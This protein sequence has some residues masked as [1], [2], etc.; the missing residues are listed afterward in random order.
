MNR[1][2][3]FSACAGIISS[4]WLAATGKGL[5]GSPQAAPG[6]QWWAATIPANALMPLNS[7]KL[8]AQLEPV[9]NRMH[10]LQYA[11][12]LSEANADDGGY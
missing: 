12:E 6:V 3:L 8:W 11:C 1:R 5:I 2:G 10:N 7:A 4:A 9:L